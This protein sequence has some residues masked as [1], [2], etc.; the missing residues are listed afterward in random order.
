MRNR[1]AKLTG[2]AVWYV[3]QYHFKWS[4]NP[5]DHKKVVFILFAGRAGSKFLIDHLHRLPHTRFEYE[6]FKPAALAGRHRLLRMMRYAHGRYRSQVYAARSLR[7]ILRRISGRTVGIK[8]TFDQVEN[9]GMTVRELCDEFPEAKYLILYRR[10]LAEQFLSLQLAEVTGQWGLYAGETNFAEREATR[11]YLSR[12]EFEQYAERIKRQYRQAVRAL[13]QSG[14]KFLVL[15]YEDLREDP[16]G[17]MKRWIAPFLE[18]EVERPYEAVVQRQRNRSVREV[19]KNFEEVEDLFSLEKY[20]FL[21]EA[22]GVE[23]DDC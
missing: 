11:L 16:E 12:Q 6:L 18:S 14:R 9:S 5:I 2:N 10:R 17:H 1:L 19:V 7:E 13:S 4:K 22:S 20:E 15:A 3:W 23:A 8:I 21:L